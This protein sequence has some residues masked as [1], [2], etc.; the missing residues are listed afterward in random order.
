MTILGERTKE[1][2]FKLKILC[3]ATCPLAVKSIE[4]LLW[5]S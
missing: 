5:A 2:L 4:N 3:W 1:E